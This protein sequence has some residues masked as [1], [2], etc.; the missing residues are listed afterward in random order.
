MSS[1]LQYWRRYRRTRGL[2]HE[3]WALAICLAIGLVVMP[4][5]IYVIGSWKLGPYVDGGLLA[6]G[7]DFYLALF[8]GSAAYW[9]VALG[10]YAALW[11]LR[12]ARYAWRR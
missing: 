4:V 9:L 6:L 11:L 3:L 7:R 10:P 1:L 12:A 5:M 8:S 2:T